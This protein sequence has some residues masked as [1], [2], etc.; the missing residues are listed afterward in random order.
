LFKDDED[1]REAKKAKIDTGILRQTFVL[2][3]G[4]VSI[5]YFMFADFLTQSV[6]TY[7][8][9]QEKDFYAKSESEQSQ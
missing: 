7:N 8:D 4:F 2:L 9:F 6:N 1:D 5:A 3:G